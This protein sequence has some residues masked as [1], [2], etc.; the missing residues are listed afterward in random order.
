MSTINQNPLAGFFRT[1]ALEMELPSK[2]QWYPEGALS[3]DS[4]VVEVFPMTAKDDIILQSPDSLMNGNATAKVIESCIPAIRDGREIPSIDLDAILIAIRVATNGHMLE[5][6]ASC[7]SCKTMNDYQ[8]DLRGLLDRV[9]APDFSQP[10][11][12]R[13]LKFFLKPQPFK[14]LNTMNLEHYEEQ[15]LILAVQ[16]SKDTDEQ[17]LQKLTDIMNKLASLTVTQMVNGIHHIELPDGSNVDNPDNIGEF[18]QNCDKTAYTQIRNKVN[19]VREVN[20]DLTKF[21]A[22]CTECDHEY[23]TEISLEYSNFFG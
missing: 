18:L 10:I 17:K 6:S 16:N 19:Q 4:G 13:D 12:V 8:V 11:E 21:N 1:S 5:F 14:V 20:K 7:P 2:G 9:Q 23:V 15:K 3:A 22:V